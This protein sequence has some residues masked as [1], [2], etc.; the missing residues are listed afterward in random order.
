[1]AG[2]RRRSGDP[3]RG[4]ILMTVAPRSA[5]RPPASSPA[6]V[7]ASS[8]TTTPSSVPPRSAPGSADN[9]VVIV[10]SS[11]QPEHARGVLVEPLLLDVIFQG[12]VHVLVDQRLV[13]LADQP[14]REAHQ[15]LVLDQRVAELHEHLPA[16]AGLTEILR[17]MRRGVHVKLWMPPDQR[18][19]LVDPRPAAE[20]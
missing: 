15:H 20:P 9:S 10:R 1:M 6:T 4:S 8:R 13:L 19:H 5:S 12:Q 3:S 11:G 17:A 7:C 18:D 2:P 14:R 16:R